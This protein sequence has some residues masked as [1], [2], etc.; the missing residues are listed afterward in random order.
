MGGST[1]PVG[2]GIS[3]WDLSECSSS[4]PKTK[5]KYMKTKINLTVHVKGCL[6]YMRA[7]PGCSPPLDQ[8]QLR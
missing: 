1:P 4:F 7:C 2:Q 8:R 5:D 3:V 6:S